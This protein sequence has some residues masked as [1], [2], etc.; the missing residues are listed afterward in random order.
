MNYDS[1]HKKTIL[2]STG[3]AA[4]LAVSLAACSDRPSEPES[5]Q[6]NVQQMA[7]DKEAERRPGSGEAAEERNDADYT[8]KYSEPRESWT[9]A[10]SGD[11][12]AVTDIAESDARAASLLMQQLEGREGFGT[13]KVDVKDGVARLEGQVA[14]AV[15]RREAETLALAMEEIVAVE[16]ELEIAARPE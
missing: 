5:A 16:N 4:V 1:A 7:R 14:S 13:I 11:G 12:M 8:D 10:N 15:Q 9:G 2:L 3:L 6:Q